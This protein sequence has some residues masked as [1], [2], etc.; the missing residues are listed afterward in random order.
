MSGS[1]NW[2]RKLAAALQS[3]Q[4]GIQGLDRCDLATEAQTQ[5]LLRRL[6]GCSPERDEMGSREKC[7]AEERRSRGAEKQRSREAEER[8]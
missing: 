1:A 3:E 8:N 6:R 5:V 7:G 4:L 2:R